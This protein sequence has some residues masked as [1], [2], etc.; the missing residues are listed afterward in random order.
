VPAD[1][2]STTRSYGRA[3]SLLTASLATAGVLAYVYFAVASHSLDREAYGQIVVLWSIVFLLVSTLFRPVEQLLAKTVAELSEHERPL[4][5]AMRIAAWIQSAIGAVF[6]GAAFAFRPQIESELFGGEA[7]FF[8]VLVVAVL[9]FS[10]SYYVR[11]F[12][13]GSRRMSAYAA[14]LLLEG[15]ARLGLALVVA[16]GIVNGTAL[17]A[18]AIAAAPAASLAIVPFALA[19][20]TQG[21][22]DRAGTKPPVS[23]EGA[24]EFTLAKGGGFAAAVLVIMLSEQILLNS[25]VLFVRASEGVAAAG[26]IF[27]VLLVVRAPVVLFQAVAASLLPH[28][29]RLR[30][31]GDGSSSEAFSQSVNLT[32][33]VIVGFAAAVA[34]GLFAIGPQVMEVAF[35]DKFDYDRTGLLLVAAGM[36]FYLT[37]ATLNQAALAQGQVRRAAACWLGAATVFALI[38]LL[39]VLDAFRRVEGGFALCAAIL[40]GSLW[41]VSRGSSTSGYGNQVEPGSAHEVEVQLAAADN[42]I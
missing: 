4:G 6:V 11:G 21:V 30:S 34:I 25:G 29:T 41:L 33:V 36:G 27:N 10:A 42:V 32:I 7:V 37:A 39:P 31:R 20:S 3:A 24:P 40:C 28:L 15:I 9:A 18:V 12:F 35:G 1:S 26:F 23:A 19:R 2:S 14:L 5:H 38:N 8:W 22:P 13:A 16:T 17:V